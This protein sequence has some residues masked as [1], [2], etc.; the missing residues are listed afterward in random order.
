MKK[1]W[2]LMFTLIT[3]LLLAAC[4]SDDSSSQSSNESSGGSK[5]VESLT[6]ASLTDAVGLSP[7][8]TNDSA[9]SNVIEHVYETLLKEMLR[10]WKL[11]HY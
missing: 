7:I 10:R 4:S 1:N 6:Y 3:A 5:E 8:M 9:S 11:N 2:F